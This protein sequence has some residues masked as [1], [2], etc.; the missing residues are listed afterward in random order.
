MEEIAFA[1][2]RWQVID[3]SCAL[4][5]ATSAFEPTPHQI[6]YSDHR[7]NLARAADRF[8]LDP[9]WWPDGVAWASETVTLGTHSGTHMDAPYHYGPFSGGKPSRTM[10]LVP[11]NWCLGP[12]VRIDMRTASAKTGI[13]A[14]D[15][16]QALGEIPY[17]LR[18]QDIVLI[19]TGAS[20]HFH[21]A[22]YHQHYAGLR[23]SATQ[24][25]VEQ[26]VRVIGI[27]AY[28]LD[29]PFAQMADD[30]RAGDTAQVWES[31]LY[32]REREYLQIEKLANLGGIPVS[33]GFYVM[34]FPV[35]IAGASAAWARAVALCE[36]S[37]K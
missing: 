7:A 10:D 37:G 24:W 33:H 30:A 17:Q 3:L 18:P 21:E 14:E 11:L 26:G 27:D 8:G 31:H 20:A 36:L 22:G 25:L 29:R 5:N 15:V 32:G 9:G 28:G 35:K 6:V 34:A 16:Q 19:Y 4:D 23:R 12:G 2:R 1:G 13:S